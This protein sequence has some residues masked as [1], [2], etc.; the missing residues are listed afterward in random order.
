MRI[1]SSSRC[2]RH[3]TQVAATGPSLA[4]HGAGRLA[5]VHIVTYNAELRDEEGLI[6]EGASGRAFRAILEDGRERV[7]QI[8]D[9]PLGDIASTDIRPSCRGSAKHP[10]CA[11]W[12]TGA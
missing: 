12:S 7:R 8:D 5:A 6:G 11:M 1:F 4:G 3:P 10:S 2:F 9:D